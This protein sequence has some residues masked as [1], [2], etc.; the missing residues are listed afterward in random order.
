MPTFDM[1][2]TKH[3]VVV[4]P[5]DPAHVGY[6]NDRPYNQAQVII[7]L[8]HFDIRIVGG[9]HQYEHRGCFRLKTHPSIFK[10]RLTPELQLKDVLQDDIFMAPVMADMAQLAGLRAAVASEYKG[11]PKTVAR[12]G[13]IIEATVGTAKQ[14]ALTDDERADTQRQVEAFLSNYKVEAL[15]KAYDKDCVAPVTNYSAMRSDLMRMVNVAKGG[16]P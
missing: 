16:F 2:G 1:K 13:E 15:C 9:E 11:R 4:M 6:P 8:E 14:R 7:D 10:V 12:I 3:L 5:N